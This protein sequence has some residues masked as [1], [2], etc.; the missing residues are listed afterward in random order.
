MKTK[1][2]L[3]CLFL[4]SFS[5]IEYAQDETTTPTTTASEPIEKPKP[6]IWWG[7]RFGLD[8]SH[9][10]YDFNNIKSQLGNNYQ[11]G[12][13]VQ[14]G[15]KLYLQPEAYY[16][17]YK[18]VTGAI[19][20]TKNFIKV[21]VLVGLRFF[22]I[23]LISL[24]LMGGPQ[25]SFQLDKKDNFTGIQTL[26]WQVGGG[27]DILGFITADLRYTLQQGQNVSTQVQNFSWNSTG[28]NLTVGLKLR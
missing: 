10:T 8:L 25:F 21:P 14:F 19:D 15:E 2:F 11:A 7:P 1:F 17:S 28:L 9:F 23:G 26:S 5:A 27:A 4:V 24:H 16:A 20:S 12:I 18:S 22:N 6:K 3:L 13:M